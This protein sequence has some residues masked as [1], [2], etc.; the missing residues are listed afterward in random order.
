MENMRKLKDGAQYCPA[1]ESK[2]SMEDKTVVRTKD[3]GDWE[4][5]TE[6]R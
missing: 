3:S 6:T 5:K 2:V 1:Q 4:R